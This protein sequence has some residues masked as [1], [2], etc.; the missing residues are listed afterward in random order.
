MPGGSC[1]ACWS[2]LA[3]NIYFSKISSN[4]INSTNL[5]ICLNYHRMYIRSTSMVCNKYC[6]SPLLKLTLCSEFLRNAA[7]LLNCKLSLYSILCFPISKRDLGT[8]MSD[9]SLVLK[10]YWFCCHLCALLYYAQVCTWRWI[11]F[12]LYT[13]R[14]VWATI[15][16]KTL[17]EA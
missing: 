10:L 7:T 15:L 11:L 13:A 16:L 5:T 14:T 17:L 2:Y 6:F 8:R 9:S 12:N 4:L 1:W 3:N